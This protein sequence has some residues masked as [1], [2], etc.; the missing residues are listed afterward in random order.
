MLPGFNQLLLR[1]PPI[2][3]I[4]NFRSYPANRQT[5]K[6]N[7]KQHPSVG[8]VIIC[9]NAVKVDSYLLIAGESSCFF[10][11]LAVAT[12]TWPTGCPEVKDRAE[13]FWCCHLGVLLGVTKV[14]DHSRVKLHAHTWGRFLVDVPCSCCLGWPCN[15]FITRPHVNRK[16]SIRHSHW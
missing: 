2:T 1:P 8:E 13:C 3:F 15:T 5:D 12:V 6:H 7:R 10:W 4:H 14:P 16:Y 11:R 9:H